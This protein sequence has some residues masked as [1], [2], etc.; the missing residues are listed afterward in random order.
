VAVLLIGSLCY[1]ASL[2]APAMG[3]DFWNLPTLLVQ[4]Q[5]E[6]ER[7]QQWLDQDAI[8]VHVI[9]RKQQVIEDVINHR[10]T[11]KEA[12][13]RFRDLDERTP[14][15]EMDLFRRAH[16]G[17]SDEE[18]YYRAVIEGV[19]IEL[20]NKPEQAR[21]ISSSLEA[22]LGSQFKHEQRGPMSS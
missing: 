14:N 19:R 22:E 3:L 9:D 5:T 7:Q 8:L 18:R 12:A 17:E 21:A 13:E 4:L 16:E 1:L 10:L 15:F 6:S 20:L 2:W 11:L